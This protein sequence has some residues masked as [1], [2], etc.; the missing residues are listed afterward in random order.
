MVPWR[1]GKLYSGMSD[2]YGET[3]GLLPPI[4]IGKGLIGEDKEEMK[5]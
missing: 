2:S 4:S 5:Q 1:M 3:S